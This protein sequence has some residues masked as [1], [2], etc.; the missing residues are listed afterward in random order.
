VPRAARKGWKSDRQIPKFKALTITGDMQT[1]IK[2][3]Q[4]FLYV[5]RVGNDCYVMT[6]IMLPLS[7]LLMTSFTNDL[8]Y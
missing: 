1:W 6:F 4:H 2:V 5:L 3:R 8:F 7:V